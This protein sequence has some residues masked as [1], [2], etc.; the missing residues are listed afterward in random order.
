MIWSVCWRKDGGEC[1]LERVCVEEALETF[2]FNQ[3][4]K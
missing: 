2:F 4:Q 3:K 1:L